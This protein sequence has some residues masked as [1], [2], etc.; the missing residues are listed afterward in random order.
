[1]ILES[2]D[3]IIYQKQG[4]GGLDTVTIAE[5]DCLYTI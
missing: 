5:S 2:L 4:I 3:I 1:M